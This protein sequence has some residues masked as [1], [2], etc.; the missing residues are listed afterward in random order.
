MSVKIKKISGQS[1]VEVVV[2]IG[3]VVL[4][5]SGVVTLVV[6]SLGARNKGFDRK[7]ATELAQ[8]VTEKSCQIKSTT[9]IVFGSKLT[10]QRLSD[11]I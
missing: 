6:N 11:Q 5:V 2:S 9:P 8:K 4:V 10:G 3:L 1:L 7:K